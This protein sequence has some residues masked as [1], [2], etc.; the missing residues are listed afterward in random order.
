MKVTRQL[1]CFTLFTSPLGAN[2]VIADFNDNFEGPLGAFT[3]GDGQGGGV[4]WLSGDVWANTGTISVIPGDLVAPAATGYA[5]TQDPTSQ[6]VQGTFSSGRH[7]TRAVETPMN[8]TVWFSFLLNQPTSESRGGITFNQNASSPGN[9]RIVATGSEMR[10]GLGATLQPGGGGANLL[11]IGETALIL[12]RL[13]I[14]NTGL[15]ETLDV[16]INPDVSG[17]S[18]SLPAPDTTLSEEAALLDTGVTRVGIQSYSADGLGGIVDSLRVSDAANAFEVVTGQGD[19]VLDD[20]NLVLSTSNPFA[21]TVITTEEAPITADILLENTGSTETLVVSDTTAI[22]GADE[23]SYSIVTSLPLN[24]APGSTATLQIQLDPSGSARVSE[25]SLSLATNDPSSPDFTIPLAARILEAEGNQLLNGDFESDPSTPDNWTSN[26]NTTI[27]E[28]IAPG[29]TFSA[30]LSPGENLRQ[31]VFAEPD[32]FF[33]CF[34]QAP[35][36]F[37]RALSVLINAPGGNINLRFRGTSVGAEQT[38]NL[39]DQATLNDAWGASIEL[40]AVEPGATYQLRIIGK[41]WDGIAPTYEIE[42][43]APNS[44]ALAGTVTGLNRFQ[45]GI[46]TGPPNEVRF[47]SEFGGSPGFVIDGVFFAN[48]APPS[49]EQPEISDLVYNP[50]AQ[51]TTLTLITQVGARYS[52]QVSENLE[53]WDELNDFIADRET[54]TYVEGGVITPQRFYRLELLD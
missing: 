21:G 8:G 3:V 29:S 6:S 10:L 36:T 22:S 9:P 28:G 15:A 49:R 18:S 2:T 53:D 4:G 40:P 5:V 42:L 17:D 37:E 33:E 13:S 24:I 54:E 12:G 47:T 46:P 26:G 48:G 51:T 23:E 50:V 39:F 31:A 41:A 14:D 34:F 43:S 27:A 32:W 52:L 19:I 30:S 45:T 25:A 16:W 44:L 11:T 7:T 1:L 35:D 20:P 38:W